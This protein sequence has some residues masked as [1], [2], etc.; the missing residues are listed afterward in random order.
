MTLPL[1]PT[2]NSN[3]RPCRT[4]F[5]ALGC[6]A[7]FIIH[8]IYQWNHSYVAQELEAPLDHLSSNL[9][10]PLYSL[11]GC[12]DPYASDNDNSAS[13]VATDNSIPMIMI[14]ARPKELVDPI[15]KTWT[16]AGF[17]VQVFNTSKLS[18]EYVNTR[19][20]ASSGDNT[21][22]SK[23]FFIYQ[24]VFSFILSMKAENT[25]RDALFDFMVSIE[26][27]TKLV[28]GPRFQ[29]ELS[30]ALDQEYGY[31]SFTKNHNDGCIYRF[32]TPAQLWSR[33]MMEKVLQV[34]DDTFCR[35]PIDMFVA[36]Q[37][38]WYVTQHQLV[39]HVGTRLRTP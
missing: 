33:T 23:L 34:E 28:D 6:A 16:D 25:D 14:S 29:Q 9:W 27:D 2:S 22:K 8:Q 24:E 31:Y 21:F 19:C 3:T 30:F 7:L 36:Q 35:L 39:Q 13:S 4:A 12:P 20:A 26:D 10:K 37:G 11:G 38:P 15:L 17:H 1:L 18:Q 5:A 32:G